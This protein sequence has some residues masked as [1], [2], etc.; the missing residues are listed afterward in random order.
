MTAPAVKEGNVI[1][2]AGRRFVPCSETTYEQDMYV[3]KILRDAGLAQMTDGFDPVK[4]DLSEAAQDL[5]VRAFSSGKLFML[6]AATLEEEGHEWTMADAERNGL[7][8]SRLKKLP[9]KEALRGSIVGILTGFLISGV[10]SSRISGRSS[11]DVALTPAQLNDVAKSFTSSEAPAD[12]TS[13][14]G[15]TSSVSSLDTTQITTG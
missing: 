14:N 12:A 4:D 6:L 1:E 7:F 11:L 9:D 15:T 5:I 3:M 10:L 8:F 13:E 2:V